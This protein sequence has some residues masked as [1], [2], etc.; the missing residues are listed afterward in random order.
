LS[1]V[2]VGLFTSLALVF[3]V[4]PGALQDAVLEGSLGLGLNL[5]LLGLVLSASYSLALPVVM[6]AGL[7]LLFIARELY[8]WRSLE[9]DQQRYEADKLGGPTSNNNNDNN[10]DDGGNSVTPEDRNMSERTVGPPT[11]SRISNVLSNLAPSAT[12]TANRYVRSFAV[13]RVSVEPAEE[14]LLDRGVVS[15][16]SSDYFGDSTKIHV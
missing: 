14:S 10:I 15:V 13:R 6:A 1:A 9:R 2:A 7:L 16:R 12:A 4:L 3:C 11:I 8:V 5:A